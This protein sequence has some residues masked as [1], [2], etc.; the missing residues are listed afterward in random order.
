MN[1]T[2]MI[3]PVA[4][5]AATRTPFCRA[6]TAYADLSNLDMLSTALQGMVKQ[7]GLEGKLI[8]E[9]VAGAV[10]SHSKDFNLAREA[11]LSTQLSPLT[12][13]IT[14]QQACGTSLQAAFGIAA[15]IATG[16]IE[17]GIAAGS[18]TASD[19]PIVFSR[20]FTQRLIKLSKA[21]TIK[22]KLGLFKGFGL[23]ELA[24]I[25]PSIAEPRTGLSM[26]QHCELMAKEWEISRAAQDELAQASHNR[27]EAAYNARFY[28]DLL[29]PCAGVLRDNNL[30]YD[31]TAERLE[32]LNPVFD[33]SENGTLTAG[34]STPLTD[35]AA[36]VLLASEEW[37]EANNLPILA[38]LTYMETAAVDYVAGEGLLM[39]PTVAVANMLCKAGL[40]LQSFSHY[41]IHEAFAAQVLCT[42]KAWESEEYCRNRLGVEQALG[43]IDRSKLNQVGSSLALGHPFAATGAR[44]VGT[45]AK[46]LHETGKGRG[47][48]SVCTAGGMGVAAILEK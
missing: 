32:R 43:T 22:Q 19:A 29:T 48:I 40:S 23:S 18:D 17:C 45:L 1:N 12:P 39:A 47:L 46:Q 21:K 7:H 13:G 6:N 14:L 42:L 10:T 11:I 31:L 2:Q 26:G 25:P 37:A 35:G 9:V 20:K 15:K 41:E 27:A 30:R 36:A 8:D 5:V 24:P 38:K 44:V 28:D 16:H 34:N 33:R 3:R 4:I